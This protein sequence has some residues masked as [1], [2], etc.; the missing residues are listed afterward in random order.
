MSQKQIVDLLCDLYN[1]VPAAKDFLEIFITVDIEQLAEK[2]KKQIARDL[3]I[4]FDGSPRDVS[5]RK[6]IRDVRKM[7]IDELIIEMELFY[8]ECAF[9][10]IEK[11]SY[12]EGYSYVNAMEKIFFEALEKIDKNDLHEKYAIRINKL[13]QGGGKYG[14]FYR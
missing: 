13:R 7:G 4:P 12:W 8:V 9:E 11:M 2:Y 14:Y 1:K 6:L 10:N 5:A 3:K